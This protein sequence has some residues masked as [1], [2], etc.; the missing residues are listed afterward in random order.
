MGRHQGGFTP[1]EIELDDY[2]QVG[3]NDL[4]VQVSNLLDNTTN[5]LN[6]RGNIMLRPGLI[7]II[8]LVLI[9]QLRFLQLIS[10]YILM[11]LL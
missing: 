2:I 10:K 3:K 11:M 5:L 6:K 4:K 7:F 1:F 9:V 8:M